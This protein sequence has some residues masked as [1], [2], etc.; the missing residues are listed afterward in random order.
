MENTA[1]D[2]YITE[3]IVD[4]FLSGAVPVYYG[5]RTVFDLFNPNAFV[6]YDVE[7]PQKALSRI[8]ELEENP[9]EYDAVLNAPLLAKG[10]ETVKAYF[11]WDETVGEG[12][13]KKRIRKMIGFDS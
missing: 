3:K 12:E 9:K 8:R 7:N 5:S 10:E 11:S 4:A 2:G 13:L 6:F 1:V